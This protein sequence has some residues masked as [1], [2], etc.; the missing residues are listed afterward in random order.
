MHQSDTW[1]IAEARQRPFLVML[2]IVSWSQVPCGTLPDDDA[3]IAA[4]I[5]MPLLEFR[6]CRDVLMRGWWKATDGR[7]YHPVIAEQVIDMMN[8]KAKQRLVRKR[9]VAAGASPTLST[10]L[11]VTNL[12]VTTK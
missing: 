3:V 11:R 12:K 8:R 9:F 7:L 2:W 6:D 5:G 4:R 1:A 10:N